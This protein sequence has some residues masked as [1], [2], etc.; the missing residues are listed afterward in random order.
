MAPLIFDRA[1]LRPFDSDKV[2][3]GVPDGVAAP[4]NMHSFSQGFNYGQQMTDL[5]YA[6]PW[7]KYVWYHL[8]EGRII[9][10]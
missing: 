7:N 2:R 4:V 8:D 6:K 5:I 3:D 1:F 9:G 10:C